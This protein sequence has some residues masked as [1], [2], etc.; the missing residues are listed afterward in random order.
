M[1]REEEIRVKRNDSK[2]GGIRREVR[3][4]MQ[5]KERKKYAEERQVR[6]KE[7]T[8]EG[9]ITMRRRIFG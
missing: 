5:E 7:V 2:K 8:D 6:W 3:R 9:K 1:V 4:W